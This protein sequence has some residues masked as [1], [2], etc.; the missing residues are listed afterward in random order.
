MKAAVTAALSNRFDPCNHMLLLLLL[1]LLLLPFVL[2]FVGA[3]A[4]RRL[5]LKLGFITL[6]QAPVFDAGPDSCCSCCCCC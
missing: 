6:A 1:L 4:A 5:G 2:L 3:V